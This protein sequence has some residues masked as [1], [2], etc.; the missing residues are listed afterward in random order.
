M[1]SAYVLGIDVG[2]TSVKTVVVNVADK[3]VNFA[4]NLPTDSYII[5]NDKCSEQNVEHIIYQIDQCVSLIPEQLAE[6]V[7]HCKFNLTEE[8][9]QIFMIEQFYCYGKNNFKKC[10]DKKIFQLRI[11]FCF[12]K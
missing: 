2:T 10:E 6:K 7:G 5:H 12:F 8:Q 9:I 11:F 3:S 1:T 4:M